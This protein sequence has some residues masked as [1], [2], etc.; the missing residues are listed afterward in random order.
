MPEDYRIKAG[1]LRHPKIQKLRRRLGAEAV[2]G[3]FGLYDFATRERPDGNLTG[4]DHEDLAIAADYPNDATEWIKVLVSLR[5]LDGENGLQ[6]HGWSEHQPWVNNHQARRRS[7]QRAALIRQHR[8][9]RHVGNDHPECPLCLKARSEQ[10]LGQTERNV[11]TALDRSAA[12]CEPHSKQ[13]EPHSDQCDPQCGSAKT[14]CPDPDPDPV[15][16]PVSV[17]G[18]DPDT[19]GLRALVDVLGVDPLDC[20]PCLTVGDLNRATERA[21]S[22]SLGPKWAPAFKGL[23]PFSPAE[24]HAADLAVRRT[25]GKPN[26]GLLFR[27]LEREREKPAPTSVGVGNGNGATEARPLTDLQERMLD[28]I[29]SATDGALPLEDFEI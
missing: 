2:L 6:I 26:P 13:C 12:E 23:E 14:E 4:L 19:D 8:A 3:V 15:P 21:W 17:S 10:G 22:W 28:A 9:G 7:A 24:L 25:N 29:S 16:V 18:S 5:I 1:F 27:K 11:R 20:E